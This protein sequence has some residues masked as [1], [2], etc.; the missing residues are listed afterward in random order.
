LERLRGNWTAA[1]RYLERAAHQTPQ[2]DEVFFSLGQTYRRL[3]RMKDADLALALFR[4]RQDLQR[5][6]DETRITIA[7]RPDDV[8]LYTRLAWL[9]LQRGDRA[10][11]LDT[12]KAAQEIDPKSD[13]VQ[14]GLKA[15]GQGKA[16]SAG[17]K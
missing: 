15:L 17:G 13:E 4:R 3:G 5:R 12:L 7:I 14:R 16:A 10:G 8:K 6:I 2:Q 1:V 9:L 11:S